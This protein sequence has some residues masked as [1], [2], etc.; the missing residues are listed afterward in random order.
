[1]K[2]GNVT[3]HRI[4]ISETF[5]FFSRSRIWPKPH[6]LQPVVTDEELAVGSGK[7]PY[8]HPEDTRV[9]CPG[10]GS[11]DTSHTVGRYSPG[12]KLSC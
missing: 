2:L 3:K 11:I 4:Q 10:R 9:L 8:L 6:A 12:N 5:G 7:H 1:M